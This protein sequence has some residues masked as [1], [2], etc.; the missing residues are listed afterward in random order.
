MVLTLP[1]MAVGLAA[2]AFAVSLGKGLQMR[3]LQWRTMLLLAGAF[4][5]FQGVMPVIGWA[6]GSSLLRWIAPFD[7]W[8]VL[9]LLLVVGGKMIWEALHSEPDEHQHESLQV[10]IGEV[11]VLAVATSIDALAVGITFAVMDIPIWIAALVI[12]V[13]TFVLC[14]LAIWIGFRAGTRFRTPAE[15]LGGLILI[16]IGVQVVLEHLGVL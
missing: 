13:V 15:I 10:P 6:L 9:G 11:L 5:I 8:I 14:L 12:A 3:N 1:V 4:A 2:D 7:H 16:L